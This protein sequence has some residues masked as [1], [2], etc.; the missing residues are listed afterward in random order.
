ML[1]DVF[2][3][4][5]VFHYASDAGKLSPAS[6]RELHISRAE[7]IL[8]KQSGWL[9]L[10]GTTDFAVIASCGKPEHRLAFDLF[11]DRICGYVGSYY[12][13]LGGRVDALVFAGGIGEKSAR[14]RRR[15]VEQAS[16]LGFG[17]DD[18]ANEEEG[19]E[20][21]EKGGGK[22]EGGG[23]GGVVRDIGCKGARHRT[24]VCHTDE[25]LQMAR[26]CAN[27]EDLWS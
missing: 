22:A 7:E 19:G 15:V 5:L 2:V 24:L 14:L 21:E 25:Q 20:G 4:S 9:A 8:N 13:A 18:R 12:V 10:A 16:C 3:P 6:T 26:E 17:I 1:I 11:A 23:G 27:N